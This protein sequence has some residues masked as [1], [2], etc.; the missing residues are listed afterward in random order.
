[1]DELKRELVPLTIDVAHGAAESAVAGAHM[2]EVSVA[3]GLSD[4]T[5]HLHIVEKRVVITEVRT[6]LT[7]HI[8]PELLSTPEKLDKIKKDVARD[9]ASQL[10]LRDTDVKVKRCKAYAAH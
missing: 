3:G 8:D 5:F 2:V 1:M 9:F 7:V 10:C 4:A 6:V